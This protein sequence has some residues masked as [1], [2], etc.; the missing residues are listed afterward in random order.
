MLVNLLLFFFSRTRRH[1]RCALVTGVQTC[2]LP[3]SGRSLS[4]SLS[5]VDWHIHEMLFGFVMAA[6][7]GFVLTAVANW[8]GRPPISGRTLAGLALL[9]IL[10]RG[11]NLPFQ[12]PPIWLVA[13]VDF[14]LPLVLAL[15]VARA[16][17]VARSWHYL[18]QPVPLSLS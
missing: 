9:W 13:A 6:I 14:A 16:S 7:A 18:V 3:I 8:T 5:A 15:L 17:I 4:G 1:T 2:A 12:L 11:L 10:G